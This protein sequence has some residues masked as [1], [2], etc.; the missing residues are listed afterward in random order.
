MIGEAGYL[1]IVEAGYLAIGEAGY[2]PIIEARYYIDIV[3]HGIT[4]AMV[5]ESFNKYFWS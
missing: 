5:P 4:S 3:Y 2:L 1:A